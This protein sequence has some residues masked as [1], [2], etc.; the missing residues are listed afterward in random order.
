MAL[1]RGRLVADRADVELL[2]RGRTE[3]HG[4][5]GTLSFLE[6]RVEERAEAF[7]RLGI[8]EV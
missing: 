6:D 4:R 3:R 5:C 1:E 2:D 8:G 7:R